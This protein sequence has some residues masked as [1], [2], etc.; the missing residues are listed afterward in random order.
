MKEPYKN[1][2]EIV[3]IGKGNVASHLVKAL[4]PYMKTLQ[5]DSRSLTNL[6]SRCRVAIIAVSDRAIRE[7]AERIK[8][9]V[10]LI[11]HTSGSVPIEILEGTADS[12]GVFY[13]LQTFT[14]DVEMEYSD[15]PFFIEGNN[16]NTVNILSGIAHLVSDKV[17][18]A[19]SGKRK[20]L[21]LASVFACNFS[22]HLVDIAD[23]I[24]KEKGMDYTL[25]LPLLK[26][27]VAKL[28][29]ISPREAQTG[30]AMRKDIPVIDSHLKMLEKNPELHDLY[31][32]LSIEIMNKSL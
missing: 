5:I 12:Y 18:E 4:S 15:I 31:R 26:R 3:I 16:R 32:T 30:P 9:K 22:N 28:E 29:S 11:A 27:T 20:Y 17:I 14:K 7:V 25:L 6:P 21:H 2:D 1:E 23:G 24:L 10:D 19:D 8:G 13:P